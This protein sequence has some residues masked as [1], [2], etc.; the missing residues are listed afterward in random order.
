M[1]PCKRPTEEILKGPYL[2]KVPI[3]VACSLRDLRDPD[4][5]LTA[6]SAILSQVKSPFGFF[7][8]QREMLNPERA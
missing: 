2:E 5:M 4:H 7:H 8:S 1:A 3:T 6:G